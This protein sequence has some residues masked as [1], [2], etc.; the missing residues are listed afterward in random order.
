MREALTPALL[1]DSVAEYLVAVQAA[2]EV[3]RAG[4][5]PGYPGTC[6]RARPSSSVPACTSACR[7][8]DSMRM[9]GAALVP[10]ELGGYEQHYLLAVSHQIRRCDGRAWGYGI[11]VM[12]RGRA[13]WRAT[14]DGRP[15]AS[16]E[17]KAPRDRGAATEQCRKGLA[18]GLA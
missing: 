12:G 10:D 18:A 1:T 2:F 17:P 5:S 7:P 14:R 8:P 11:T 4:P 3:K 16:E 15:P 6:S 13:A 9:L